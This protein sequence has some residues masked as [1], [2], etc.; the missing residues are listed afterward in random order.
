MFL[1]EWVHGADTCSSVFYNQLTSNHRCM[2]TCVRTTTRQPCVMWVRDQGI[3]SNNQWVV[4][5][6]QHLSWPPATSSRFSAGYWLVIIVLQQK[7]FRFH[8]PHDCSLLLSG[9]EVHVLNLKPAQLP[10]QIAPDE[11]HSLSVNLIIFKCKVYHH[12]ASDHVHCN[13]GSTAIISLASLPD[14]GARTDAV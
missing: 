6:N 14:S 3:V 4:A 8:L 2:Y 11:Q 13:L 10:L 9:I 12:D 7:I 5:S 1:L